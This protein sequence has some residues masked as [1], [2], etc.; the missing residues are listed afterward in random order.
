MNDALYIAATGMQA[1]QAQ[2]DAVANNV[3]N[4]NTPGFKRVKVSFHDVVNRAGGTETATAAT[5]ARANGVLDGTGVSSAT[6]SRQFDPGEIKR[7]DNPMDIAVHGA[8]FI[9]LTAVDGSLAYTRGGALQVNAD[10]YLATSEGLVLKQRIHVPAEVRTLTIS[11]DG[12][13]LGSDGKSKERALGRIDLVT[14][15]NPQALQS[16]GGNVYRATPEA[17]DPLSAIAGEGGAGR[18]MQG[19]LEQSNVKLIDEMVQMMVAQRAYEMNVKVIQAAD[20]IAGLTNNMR[21]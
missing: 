12:E 15:A 19:Q 21:K 7:T 4:V 6:L 3:A 5:S 18:L 20:E 8:G 9:E 16:L 2:I 10:G 14:F 1:H 13:V 11:Q 17:G